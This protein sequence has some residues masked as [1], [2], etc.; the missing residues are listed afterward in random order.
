MKY[1]FFTLALLTVPGG[2]INAQ[3]EED[4]EDFDEVSTEAVKKYQKSFTS[5]RIINGHSVETQD[6]GEL[7]F[8][9]EHRFGDICTTNEN[10]KVILDAQNMIGFDNSSDIRFAF[11]YGIT[12]NMLIGLGRSKGAG[13]PYRA[14]IDGFYKYRFF[15]QGQNAPLSVA[16]L[17]MGSYSYMKAADDIELVT[18]FPKQAHR[19]AYA[20]QL[21]MSRNFMDL[22]SLALVPTW[23]HRNY[24]LSTDA[25]DLFSLGVGAKV[26]IGEKV[27]INMEY[28]HV[29]EPST[30]SRLDAQNSLS[31]AVEWHT[32]GHDFKIDLTNAKG[33]GE[34]QFITGT[35]S[36]W[37]KGQFRLGFS[38]TR[39]F[40]LTK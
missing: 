7:Q 21:H 14:L 28:Y 5:T 23:V 24:V 25:N 4:F 27:S 17:T 33:F 37:T 1:L 6:K 11:E 10:G 29:F 39:S 13:N 18:H 16:V 30:V 8:R 12:D 26:D 36:D 34:T 9:I 35:N 20:T 3:D 32:F 2:T 40:Q 19:M 22:F 38:I 31:L 15:S